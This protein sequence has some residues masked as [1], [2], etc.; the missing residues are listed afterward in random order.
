[1]GTMNVSL[2]DSLKI[3]CLLIFCVFDFPLRCMDTSSGAV[4]GI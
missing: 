1:M 4:S 3:H 2:D